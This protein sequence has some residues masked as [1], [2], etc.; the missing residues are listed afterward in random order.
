MEEAVGN[1][2]RA[3]ELRSMCLQRTT[4]GEGTEEPLLPLTFGII[5]EN[6]T[7][8]LYKSVSKVRTRGANSW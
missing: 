3:D 4:G 8:S 5:D 1:E 6:M 7:D 2:R